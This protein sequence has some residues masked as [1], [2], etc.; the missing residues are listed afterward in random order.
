MGLTRYTMGDEQ[1][2]EKVGDVVQVSGCVTGLMM[3]P[4]SRTGLAWETC[5][6][7]KSGQV[8]LGHIDLKVP[9]AQSKEIS[10]GQLKI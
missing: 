10:N 6:G 2:E 3:V 1:R 4:L 7:R 9:V 5:S 8:S